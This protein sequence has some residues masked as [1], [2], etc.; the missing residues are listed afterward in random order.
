MIDLKEKITELYSEVK[1]D[2]KHV[3]PKPDDGPELLEDVKLEMS[4]RDGVNTVAETTV[5]VTG[6]NARAVDR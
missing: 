3:N 2:T 5:V 4:S 1:T 6:P